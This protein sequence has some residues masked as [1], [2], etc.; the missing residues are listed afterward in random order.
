M[1]LTPSFWTTVGVVPHA[2][3]R[4]TT[5]RETH[6]DGIGKGRSTVVA[7]CAAVEVARVE[8]DAAVVAKGES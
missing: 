2:R 4:Y 3:N 1:D 5:P 6:R 7:A 8:V